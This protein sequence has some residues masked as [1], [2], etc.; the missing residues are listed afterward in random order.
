MWSTFLLPE[1]Q[2]TLSL[3]KRGYAAQAQAFGWSAYGR[4]RR[5]VA[6]LPDSHGFGVEGGTWSIGRGHRV[7][8]TVMRWGAAEEAARR[9]LHLGAPR[10]VSGCERRPMAGYS[11]LGRR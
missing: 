3:S 9:C 1:N 7:V 4:T 2:Q 11:R 5:K 8:A 10:Q 6:A